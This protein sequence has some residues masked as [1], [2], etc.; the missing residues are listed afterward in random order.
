MAVN[1]RDSLVKILRLH[2]LLV[3]SLLLLLEHVD[4]DSDSNG[5][6]SDDGSSFSGHD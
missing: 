3:V 6:G 4:R 5:A 2:S 1:V